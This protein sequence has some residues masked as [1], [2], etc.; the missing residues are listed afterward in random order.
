MSFFPHL[1]YTIL[2]LLISPV[3]SK[4]RIFAPRFADLLDIPSSAGLLRICLD[5]FTTY[6]ISFYLAHIRLSINI[7]RFFPLESSKTT[8]LD[9]GVMIHVIAGIS[10]SVGGERSI[11]AFRRK[12]TNT[13][14][15]V[16]SRRRKPSLRRVL[17]NSMCVINNIAMD[18]RLHSHE[19][20]HE[21]SLKSITK[22]KVAEPLA[23][24][25]AGVLLWFEVQVC[26]WI[27]LRGINTHAFEHFLV[28]FSLS[29]CQ[30]FPLSHYG[31][32]CF[33]TLA[34][35]QPRRV[36]G[37]MYSLRPNHIVKNPLSQLIHLYGGGKTKR[38]CPLINN[39]LSFRFQFDCRRLS[40]IKEDMKPRFF[41]IR[42]EK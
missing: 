30:N 34:R 39:S 10:S 7:Q 12:F 36:A 29:L 15:C 37:T 38:A 27:I 24:L 28:L 23:I 17:W 31:R 9:G 41:S 5:L 35:H 40:Q 2:I 22:C 6:Q 3:A 4:D 13:H 18:C 33:L 11:E 25:W 42:R 19:Y 16:R 1:L 21:W 26:P 20:K 8:S 14:K 32:A